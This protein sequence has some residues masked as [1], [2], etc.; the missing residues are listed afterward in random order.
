MLPHHLQNMQ[1]SRAFPGSKQSFS[2]FYHHVLSVGFLMNFSIKEILPSGHAGYHYIFVESAQ[3]IKCDMNKKINT[4][5][6]NINHIAP[7]STELS[8]SHNRLSIWSNSDN[9]GSAGMNENGWTCLM[10]CSWCEIAFEAAPE[11][12][13][14]STV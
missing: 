9:V 7:W 2:I 14:E 4:S 8:L 12:W 5:T 6:N 10:S 11:Y 13:T 3:F 1:K